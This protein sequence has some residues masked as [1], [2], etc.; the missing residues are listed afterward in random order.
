MT[1]PRRERTMEGDAG[2]L[3]SP[4]LTTGISGQVDA[5]ANLFGKP[6]PAQAVTTRKRGTGSVAVDGA[7]TQPCSERH[8]LG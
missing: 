7:R 4:A 5:A 2:A 3:R 1:N 6:L 8:E